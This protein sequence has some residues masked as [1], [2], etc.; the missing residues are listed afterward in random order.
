MRP[1]KKIKM[2]LT[3]IAML[4]IILDSKT[5]ISGA[6]Q[7][8]QMCIYTVI[9][10][11]F[12]LLVLAT[13]L[14]NALCGLSLKTVQKIAHICGVPE[15]GE[16]LLLV[17]LI[18]G[19]PVGAQC[20]YKAYQNGS[21]NQYDAR[22]MLGFCSNAGPAFIFGMAGALFQSFWIPWILW[23]IQILSAM[24]TGYLL[25][26]KRSYRI[27]PQNMNN[28]NFLQVM[29][30]AVHAMAQICG[31]VVLFQLLITML[32]KWVLWYFPVEIQVLIGGLLE[33]VSGC[34]SLHIID[35]EVL[36]MILCAA[37]LSGGGICVCMQTVSVTGDLGIASYL[38]GKVIQAVFGALLACFVAGILFPGNEFL[39]LSVLCIPLIFLVK[40]RFQKISVAFG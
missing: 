9:P 10:A 31:W 39:L 38:K 36:R 2:L 18:G 4:A 15:G 16:S 27:S 8:V 17:G 21:L 40:W 5:A 25:P 23:L 19:Y 24:I 35:S 6:T 11:L 26:G 29:Q 33:L 13:Y 12:P 32:T 7:G 37:F 14:T 22:R 20:I 30:N 28:T 34:S 3:S 1:G